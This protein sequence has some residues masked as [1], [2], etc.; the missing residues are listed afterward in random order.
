MLEWLVGW[1]C[2]CEPQQ[3]L[4]GCL[5]RLL[6]AVALPLAGLAYPAREALRLRMPCFSGSVLVS[7][8]CMLIL[9]TPW[10]FN[11][12]LVLVL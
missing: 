11:L 1:F 3:T 8:S 6:L 9:Q 5:G 10:F 7:L 4:P 2:P 12:W